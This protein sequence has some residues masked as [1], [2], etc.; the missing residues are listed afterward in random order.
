MVEQRNGAVGAE[1]Q[2]MEPC[3]QEIGFALPVQLLGLVGRTLVHIGQEH[4]HLA[5]GHVGF[6]PHLRTFDVGRVPAAVVDLMAVSAAIGALHL[7]APHRVGISPGTAVVGHVRLGRGPGIDMGQEIAGVE[8]V[9]EDVADRQV[10]IGRHI[11]IVF[12]SGHCGAHAY[13]RYRLIEFAYHDLRV[14]MFRNPPGYPASARAAWD[15]RPR[16]GSTR[17]R[18]S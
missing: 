2:E 14:V 13:G 6:G 8:S 4:V 16:R 3:T 18:G 1:H 12:A 9:A 5:Q 11:Q 15:N 7:V 10:L 17:G